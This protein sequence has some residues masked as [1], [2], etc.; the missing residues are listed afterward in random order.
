[1]LCYPCISRESPCRFCPILRMPLPTNAKMVMSVTEKHSKQ[2]WP[3]HLA[4]P[5]PFHSELSFFSTFK[6]YNLSRERQ[7]HKHTRCNGKKL[8]LTILPLKVLT[9]VIPP[10]S[11]NSAR[12]KMHD[13]YSLSFVYLE[14]LK[15][16]VIKD[17]MT[18]IRNWKVFSVS[19]Q[20][21]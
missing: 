15:K 11:T 9:A 20:V 7:A 17:V 21:L 5:F 4:L 1:M 6:H 12:H 3:L 8:S 13:L 18:S 16:K 19:R 10:V 2:A 14:R